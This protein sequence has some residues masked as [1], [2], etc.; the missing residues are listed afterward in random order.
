MEIFVKFVFIC[1]FFQII[2]LVSLKIQKIRFLGT[3]GFC[4]VIKSS[5]RMRVLFKVLF[6]VLDCFEYFQVIVAGTL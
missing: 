3:V 1:E 6:F 5:S 4:T 2:Y